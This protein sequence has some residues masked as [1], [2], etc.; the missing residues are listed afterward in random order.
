LAAA[1]GNS[2]VQS[3]IH[4]RLWPCF[5]ILCLP[6]LGCASHPNAAIAP[7]AQSTS[8]R[9]PR[10]MATVDAYYAAAEA[11]DIDA[12]AELWAEDGRFLVPWL[13]ALDLVGKVAIRDS[14]A[15]RLANMTRI[16]AKRELTPLASGDQVFVRAEMT[17]QYA[18]GIMYSNTLIALFTLNDESKIV[19]M[20]EWLDLE[21]F[22][23]TF[24]GLPGR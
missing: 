7:A 21:T 2:R 1:E 12:Y 4:L 13:P 9:N 15:K 19:K 18:N 17:F 20:E 23:K 11:R 8:E 16:S 24:G 22:R 6:V 14:F 10:N 5:A 3:K